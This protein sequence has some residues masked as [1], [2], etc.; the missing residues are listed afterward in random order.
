MAQLPE[1]VKDTHNIFLGSAICLMGYFVLRDERRLAKGWT[2][3]ENS[4]RIRTFLEKIAQILI[5]MW[6]G[7]YLTEGHVVSRDTLYGMAFII[8]MLTPYKKW[9][10]PQASAPVLE[11][12]EVKP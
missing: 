3:I 7:S 4:N 12:S 6:L 11:N 5:W 8:I 2:Q 10:P 1:F 9:I